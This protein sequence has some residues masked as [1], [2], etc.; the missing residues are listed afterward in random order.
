[1][2]SIK[3]I[4]VLFACNQKI[5]AATFRKIR[6]IESLFKTIEFKYYITHEGAKKIDDE[7]L[8]KHLIIIDLSSELFDFSRYSDFLLNFSSSDL[9]LLINDTLGAGRKFNTGLFI[10]IYFSLILLDRGWVDLSGAFDRDKFRSWLCPYF[11]LGKTEILRKLNWLD[12]EEARS[13]LHRQELENIEFWLERKWRSRKNASNLDVEAK[14]K[15][16]FIERVLLTGN[17]LGIRV[18]RFSKRSPFRWLNAINI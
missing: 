13:L 6:R 10:F 2:S 1:M 9:V 16:L 17:S 5:N 3:S 7:K 4:N 18:M 8:I 14:R 12:W 11:V 15:I